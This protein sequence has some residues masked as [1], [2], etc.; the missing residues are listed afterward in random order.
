M[1]VIKDKKYFKIIL[2]LAFVSVVSLVSYLT[3][4][5]AKVDSKEIEDNRYK[6][7][8]A[9]VHI[10]SGDVYQKLPNSDEFTEVVDGQA[11]LPGT[12]LKTSSPGRAQVVFP[13]GTVTRL[14]DDTTITLEE[15]ENTPFNVRVHLNSGKIWSRIVKLL[16]QES[17]ETHS[18]N[19]VASVRGTSYGHS[20]QADGTD[21]II[22]TESSIFGECT[23]ESQK[24]VVKQGF[25][26]TF[27]CTKGKIPFSSEVD[28]GDMGDDWVKFN[29]EQDEILNQQ[30]SEEIFSELTEGTTESEKT[31]K[32]KKN[33]IAAENST[34]GD[35]DEN[36]EEDSN[37]PTLLSISGIVEDECRTNSCTIEIIGTGFNG[38]A[39]I[40]L[41][42]SGGATLNV[43]Y[44][45]IFIKEDEIKI[46][47]NNLSEN[48][49]KVR[50][51][52]DGNSVVS[53]STF[54]VNPVD[55]TNV[56]QTNTDST[57]S[58][59]DNTSTTDTSNGST[60]TPKDKPSR[61]AGS[62]PG[63]L[64]KQ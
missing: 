32:L 25:K 19:L 52:Q 24:T 7:I 59:T 28:E 35:K 21:L 31:P 17:Y 61:G 64:K 38:N 53:S 43:T 1:K 26:T 62:A 58:T 27:N 36:E 23:N 14:A 54:T 55:N 13:N 6:P 56:D 2:S 63:Q 22:V 15:F 45:V 5:K 8:N 12:E 18:T 9:R 40:S 4:F 20:V 34:L 60:S 39:K 16:G 37:Q 10:Y 50:I 30:L 3:F 44:G 41:I 47:F 46:V 51:D 48:T 49:Y 33:P 42:D 29:E 57:T 11:I